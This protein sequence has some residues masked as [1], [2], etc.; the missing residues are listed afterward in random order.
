[1]SGLAFDYPALYLAAGKL[2]ADSQRLY[3]RLI[4]TEYGLLLIA[5]LGSLE[6]AKSRSY[7]VSYALIFFLSL[8]VLLIRYWRKPERDWY[9]G[10][11]LAESIKTSSWRYC[12]RSKPF[13]D[14]HNLVERRAEFRDY[15]RGVLDA[16]RHIGDKMPPEE[17]TQDQITATM[18]ATRALPLEE[19]KAIYDT[20][21]IREQRDWYSSKAAANKRASRRWMIFGVV[22]YGLAIATV[23]LRLVYPDWKWWP[24]EVFI[25]VASS[26]VGWVQVKKFNELASAYTLTAHEIGIIQTRISEIR[27]EAEFSDFVNEAEQ[28][29]SREHTQWVARRPGA[30]GA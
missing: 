3:L 25:V 8:G 6:L 2:S 1:M 7:Y 10:R 21:R 15:L 18:E 29:F 12:M 30:V 22:A 20:G 17:A 11:A 5:A 19:R 9:K 24:T 14:A 16:N 27:N 4:R 23:L 26:I 28:A 13:A